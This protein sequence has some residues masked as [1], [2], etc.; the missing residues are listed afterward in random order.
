MQENY[1]A[2]GRWRTTDKGAPIDASISV[3]FL[4]EGPL[5]TT[6]P[7]DALQGRSRVRCA[8]SSASSRQLFRF[9]TG[10]DEAAGDDPVL[11]QMFFEFANNDAQAIV[12][13]LR[14]LANARR[15][16]RSARR[17]HDHARAE[18]TGSRGAI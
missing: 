4:D 15:P 16:S 11:R 13:L 10:R 8:S 3:N 1:D 6:T 2:I 14:T 12:K 18:S 7:V 5:V 9:Y 17:R